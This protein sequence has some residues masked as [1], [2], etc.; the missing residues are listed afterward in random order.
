[1]YQHIKTQLK[2]FEE[3]EAEETSNMEENPNKA[4]VYQYLS[5]VHNDD[6]AKP[7]SCGVMA[8]SSCT[9]LSIFEGTFERRQ[10]MILVNSGAG[11]S[12]ICQ[13]SWIETESRARR[14]ST[15]I[16]ARIRTEWYRGT[17][18][19][20][21][22][23]S[24]VPTRS[25]NPKQYRRILTQTVQENSKVDGRVMDDRAKRSKKN[26]GR[27]EPR[28]ITGLQKVSESSRTCSQTNYQDEPYRRDQ[29]RNSTS[30]LVTISL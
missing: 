27:C 23:P 7:E 24:V 22:G 1:M 17:E 9:D 30:T 13:N 19:L 29:K 26:R 18:G 28:T 10:A 5:L 11:G 21:C 25:K 15:S 14:P 6:D 8:V 16:G 3:V 2:E 20:S 12:F 4:V